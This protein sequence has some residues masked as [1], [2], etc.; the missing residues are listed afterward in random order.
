M[1]L[2]KIVQ[3]FTASRVT[4]PDAHGVSRFRCTGEHYTFQGRMIGVMDFLVQGTVVGVHV[5]GV[6]AA[7]LVLA[8]AVTADSISGTYVSEPF[9]GE[10][11]HILSLQGHGFTHIAQTEETSATVNIPPSILDIR[12]YVPL[13][14]ITGGIYTYQG[15]SATLFTSE[16]GTRERFS[17]QQASM[18]PTARIYDRITPPNADTKERRRFQNKP[19]SIVEGTSA[20]YLQYDGNGKLVRPDQR[21]RGKKFLI[22][23]ELA[24]LALCYLVDKGYK[25]HYETA[26]AVC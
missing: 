2:E 12:Q 6:Y 8:R 11:F 4:E 20:F 9:P 26:S 22:S 24:N 21:G 1:P 18:I 19:R 17:A 7:Q 14:G 16:D 3:N 23:V 15:R 13:G 25:Q 10:P 5:N